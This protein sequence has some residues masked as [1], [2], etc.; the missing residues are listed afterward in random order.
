MIRTATPADS[1][2]LVDIHLDSRVDG[3]LG[4]LPKEILERHF[5]LPIL[6]SEK[7]TCL[8]YLN[9]SDV[10]VGS[11]VS[12]EDP[13][14][15]SFLTITNKIMLLSWA[16]WR[17]VKRPKILLLI[18]NH[19]RCE[20]KISKKMKSKSEKIIELQIFLLKSGEQG[21]GKGS[22]LLNFWRTTQEN[23]DC[24][25]MVK[26]QSIR[27]VK[28]YLKEG[29]MLQSTFKTFKQSIYVLSDGVKNEI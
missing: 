1:C 15:G 20:L 4:Y 23:K 3:I 21:F 22:T 5:Y 16:L 14:K 2:A 27:A 24:C 7:C 11:I 17:S 28:F 18:F 10:I 26:T 19:L 9:E 29:Y 8:V 25:F 12:V 6:L 13:Y